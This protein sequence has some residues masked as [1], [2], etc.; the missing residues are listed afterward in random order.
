MRPQL[1]SL[2]LQR[3]YSAHL[4]RLALAQETAPAKPQDEEKTELYRKVLRRGKGGAEQQ[5]VLTTQPGSI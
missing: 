1:L 5:K 2:I 3:S 4:L